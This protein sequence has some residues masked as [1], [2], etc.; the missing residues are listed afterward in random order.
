MGVAVAH[1]A[2][3]NSYDMCSTNTLNAHSFLLCY[4]CLGKGVS[5]C[6]IM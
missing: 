6:L 1:W 5:D 3:T 2:I 4:N